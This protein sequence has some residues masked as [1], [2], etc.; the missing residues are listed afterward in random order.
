MF[1]VGESVIFGRENGQATRG[2]VMKVNA[3][4][5]QIRQDEPRGKYPVGTPW[6]VHPN[7]VERDVAGAVRLAAALTGQSAPYKPGDIIRFE[8]RAY[9]SISR[10]WDPADAI[11]VVIAVRRTTVE[12]HSVSSFVWETSFTTIKEVVASPSSADVIAM[13]Q[14]AHTSLSPENLTADGERG[15]SEVNRLHAHYTAAV[16]HLEKSLGRP[17]TNAELW[18]C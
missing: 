18:G 11:G 9:N 8:S 15:R 3:K 13:L 10:S 2:T 5:V 14:A 12:V 7:L 6:R 16:R 4:S 17:A 1:Q